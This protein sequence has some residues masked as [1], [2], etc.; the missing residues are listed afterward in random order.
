MK[1]DTE[2]LNKNI[3][4]GLY[5]VPNRNQVLEVNVR[6]IEIN[7]TLCQNTNEEWTPWRSVTTGADNDFETLLHHIAT[8]R[9]GYLN[10]ALVVYSFKQF[11][12]SGL[13]LS[14]TC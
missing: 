1:S 3:N 12:Y 13:L 7:G 2:Q 10:E 9:C 5:Q 4:E 8:F 11:N 6:K 14:Q